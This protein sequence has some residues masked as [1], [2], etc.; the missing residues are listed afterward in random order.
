MGIA[1]V[2]Y[3]V[4]SKPVS[5]CKHYKLNCDKL[6]P[7]NFLIKPCQAQEKS[8]LVEFILSDNERNEHH[9]FIRNLFR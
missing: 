4:T 1:S 6:R 9:V 3:S 8:L 7:G 5:L 2:Q